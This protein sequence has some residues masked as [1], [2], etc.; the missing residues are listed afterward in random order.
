MNPRSPATNAPPFTGVLADKIVVITGSARGL[1]RA[2]AEACCKAGA[3]VIVTD[4]REELGRATTAALTGAGFKA[5]FLPLDLDNPDSI[6]AM[7]DAVGKKHGR[8]DGLVNNGALATGLGGKPF[9]TIQVEEWDRVMRVNT[10]SIW[11]A[12]KA[13]APYLRKSTAGKVVN[14]SS[15]TAL[16]GSDKILHYVASKGA[17]ISMT[18]SLSRELGADGIAV[19]AIAPGMTR[20]EATDSVSEE[21]HQRYPAGRAIKKMM[22]PEDLVGT[23]VFLLS[24]SAS[25]ITG[26]LIAVNGGYWFH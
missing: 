8:I 10:R 14:I 25:M 17:V 23:V 26:Q 16:F 20:V 24:D 7:G 1:G 18:R 13:C 5:E 6:Q 11:L 22:Y 9:E 3:H 15:D 2:Y 12:I 4:I 21:R 19:N